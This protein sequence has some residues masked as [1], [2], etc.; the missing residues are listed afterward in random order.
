MH[1]PTTNGEVP[2]IPLPDDAARQTIDAMSLWQECARVRR[3]YQDYA[4]GMY[5]KKEGEYEYLVKTK[6]RGKQE[7]LG[8]RAPETEQIY[9][10]FHK[11]KDVLEPRLKSL[12]AQL[13]MAQRLNRAVRAGRIPAIV[14]DI[15]NAF[16]AAGLAKHFTVVGTYALYA[17]EAAAGVRIAAGALATEDV[18]LLGDARKRVR[19]I[20]DMAHLGKSVLQV[21]QEVDPSFQRK[22]LENETAINDKGFM[23]E[24]LRRVPQ[25]GDP[26]PFKFS[27]A[28]EELWPVQASRAQILTEAPPFEHI[29]I[30]AT[31]RMALMRTISPKV[32]VEFKKWL[33]AQPSREVLKRRRDVS[34]AQIVQTLLDDGLLPC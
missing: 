27:D 23:V 29:V 15:L 24:F 32:F 28:E 18:D 11:R 19:F 13:A 20:A 33:S 12:E 6:A 5:W 1:F 26:H 4:F 22:E 9:V 2:Y 16:D 14:I 10:E 17:Y 25:A 30:G 31:G 7:R 21:L 34:Q 3:R 8:R